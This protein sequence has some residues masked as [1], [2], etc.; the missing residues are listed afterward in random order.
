MCASSGDVKIYDLI[1][2]SLSVK[3]S[4]GNKK[5]KILKLLM[6]IFI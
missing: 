5:V 4:S 1:I 3:T 6:L 2:E